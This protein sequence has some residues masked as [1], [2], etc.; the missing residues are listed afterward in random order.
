MAP[1]IVIETHDC[2][3]ELRFPSGGKDPTHQ[4]L[5]SFFERAV[6]RDHPEV[7]VEWVNGKQ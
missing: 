5:K 3:V 2:D 7:R 6:Q 4:K 1:E